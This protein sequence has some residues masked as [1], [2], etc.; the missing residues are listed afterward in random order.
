MEGQV[1]ERSEILQFGAGGLWVAT[2][3]VMRYGRRVGRAT[4]GQVDG[5]LKQYC[6]DHALS[7][8]PVG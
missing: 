2:F 7:F 5:H 3:G 6:F 1:Q 4:R 8:N